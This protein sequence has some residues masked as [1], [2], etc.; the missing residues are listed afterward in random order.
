VNALHCQ[1]CGARTTRAVPADDNRLRDLCGECGFVHYENP[2]PVAACLIESEGGIL[3]C[4]RAIEPRVNY[5]TAPGGY[6]E[7]GESFQEGARRECW[8]EAE[9]R[10]SVDAL[11]AVLD[12]PHIGQAYA[13]F[14]G[15]LS[16]PGFGVGVESLETRLFPIDELPW[17]ELAFPV[18][19]FALQWYVEERAAGTPHVHVASIAWK[20]SGDRYDA[21]NYDVG[22]HLAT[23]VHP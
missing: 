22:D 5:W 10:V 21:A 12:I 6:V 8:E 13:I 16:E 20:G 9:A 19:Q 4:R 7:V 11:Q 2:R 18:L 15:T 17:D 23:P 14:R 1:R 3:L